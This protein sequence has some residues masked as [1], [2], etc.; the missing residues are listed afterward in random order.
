[1]SAQS[2]YN[3]IKQ[4]LT[5]LPGEEAHRDMVPFRALSSEA[6]KAATDYRLS[7]VLL[8]MYPFENAT[9]FILTERQTY[10]GKHSGQISLPGGKV[11]SFDK[12]TE[13]TALREANEEVGIDPNKVN[14]MG[15]L[16][17]VYI[18]VSK[19]LIHPYIGFTSEMPQITKNEREV[20]SVLHCGL[21]ELVRPENKIKTNLEIDNGIKMK[22]IPAFQLN[23]KIVWGATALILNEFKV[24]LDRLNSNY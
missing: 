3:R 16:T 15:R 22:D 18:P 10:N 17:E 11:E 24:I 8:L 13:E 21:D 5:N 9:R 12:N 14:V 4:E 23:S 2:L 6:L 19:F 1:M 7:A 20:K